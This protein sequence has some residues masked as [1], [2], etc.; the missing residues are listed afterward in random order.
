MKVTL[1]TKHLK[2]YKVV[3]PNCKTETLKDTG[4]LTASQIYGKMFKK[5][6]GFK[7]YVKKQ[8]NKLFGGKK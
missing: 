5:E 3:C 7:A 2:L 1:C 6:N 8:Y 4:V